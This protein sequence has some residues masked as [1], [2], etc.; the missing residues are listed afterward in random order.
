MIGLSHTSVLTQYHTRSK[1]QRIRVLGF[2]FQVPIEPHG[3]STK[4]KAKAEY[5]NSIRFDDDQR[6]GASLEAEAYHIDVTGSDR[7]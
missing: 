2:L 5:K 6:V 1:Y 3:G 7:F 4:G